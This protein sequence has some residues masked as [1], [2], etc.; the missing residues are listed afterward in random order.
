VPFHLDEF[1]LWLERRTGRRIRLIP[2]DMEPGTPTGMFLRRAEADYL[3]YEEQASAFHQAHI[4]L[5][6]AAHMLFGSGAS[7]SVGPLLA[8]HVRP[9]VVR[10]MLGDLADST[11]TRSEG[12]A[13]A[14]LVLDGE[15]P[16][17][18]PVLA[19]HDARQLGPLHEALLRAVPEAT[20]AP[21][22]GVRPAGRCRLHRHVIEIRDAA[23][24][25]RSYRHPLVALDA[26]ATARAMGLD[27]NDLAAAAEAAVLAAAIDAKV[28]G[29]SRPDVADDYSW[30]PI[31]GNS[32]RSEAAWLVKVARAFSRIPRPAG[33]APSAHHGK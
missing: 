22:T 13:F 18:V 11:M 14:F 26:A 28:A 3:Y 5:C 9:H 8:P 17:R 23:L 33:E 16:A 25:L 21:L 31:L 7:P 1:H 6:L 32:L 29:N 20:G 24:A 12:E 4:V 2:S 10:L 27:G 15:R 30:Q 19:R